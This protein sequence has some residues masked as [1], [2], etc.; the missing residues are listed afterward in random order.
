MGVG[1]TA[2][3]SS[4]RSVLMEAVEFPESLLTDRAWSTAGSA[5]SAAAGGRP[6]DVTV[7][8]TDSFL[9]T[10]AYRLPSRGP[11]VWLTSKKQKKSQYF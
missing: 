2:V 1:G 5:C 9:R 10:F 11:W 7:S 3:A 8:S 4:V 6:L